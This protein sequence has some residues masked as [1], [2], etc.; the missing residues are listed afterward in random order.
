MS[1]A[2][3]RYHIPLLYPPSGRPC[4]TLGTPIT[5]FSHTP[6][7]NFRTVRAPC[8]FWLHASTVWQRPWRLMHHFPHLFLTAASWPNPPSPCLELNTRP[9]P[10]QACPKPLNPNAHKPMCPGWGMRYGAPTLIT[11]P[12]PFCSWPRP[13][14]VPM[15]PLGKSLPTPLG[16]A[17]P[18]TSWV[19]LLT[20][21]HITVRSC[22]KSHTAQTSRRLSVAAAIGFTGRKVL[23]HGTGAR[24]GGARLAAGPSR[25]FPAACSAP[26]AGRRGAGCAASG[27]WA[28]HAPTRQLIR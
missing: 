6:P 20:A 18:C 21:W 19:T 15:P 25:Q 27:I 13:P 12:A 11:A 23:E 3:C 16:Y 8:H 7:N 26:G 9:A 10:P 5:P 17:P 22:G 28:C 24:G 4:P 2:P 14:P 1:H